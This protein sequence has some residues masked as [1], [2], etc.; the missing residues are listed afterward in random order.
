MG[1]ALSAF[2]LLATGQASPTSAAA[3]SERDPAAPVRMCAEWE[4]AFGTLIRW[5]L[6]IPSSLVIELASDDILYVLV[7]TAGEESSA[8]S[9]FS[10]WGIDLGQVE[11]IR[12]NTYSHWTRDWGPHCVFDGDG[13]YG[14]TDPIFDG[15]P[16]VGG[17]YMEGDRG[18]VPDSDRA[19]HARGWEED[20]AVNGVLATD[21]GCAL[22]ALP[23]Y[24]TG[25]NIMADGHGIA[26]STRRMVNENAPLMSEAAFRQEAEAYLGI[27]DYHF[28]DDPETNGIQHIDC[29][30]KILDEETIMVKEVYSGHPE[31]D[32]IERLVD[33]LSVLTNCYGR[34]Y[35]IVRV[36]CGTY[37]GNRVAAYTNSLILNKKVLVPLFDIS[38]D[39][40]ALQAYADAMPGYEVLGFHYGDWYYYDALHC[41]TMGIFDSHMLLIWHRR[42]E[43]EIPQQPYYDITAMIDDRS[44]AGLVPEDLLLYWQVSGAPTWSTELLT[45]AGIDS[46]AASIPWQPV[47]TTIAYYIAAADASGRSETLPRTAPLG[48]YE[49]TVGDNPGSVQDVRTGLRLDLAPTV[50]THAFDLR[51]HLDSPAPLAID[52][53]TLG[54][55]HIQRLFDGVLAA[56]GHRTR[57]DGRDEAGDFVPGG[58]Y[59]IRA[60]G[61]RGTVSKRCL[62]LR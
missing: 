19:G 38:T 44:E 33:Q 61:P 60:A 14:I 28:L 49:F 59:L 17:C 37:Q 40:A 26:F 6:G 1:F 4:P 43:A 20:D 45:P 42:L 35:N 21:L 32:C 62:R 11:F 53:F 57:W 2:L 24:C 18:D 9:T 10:S 27:S 25:G 52:V 36:Y 48:Y 47:G 15:Y 8:S 31:Y 46:F 54:G 13:L 34:P 3:G 12:A 7:E 39:D 51:L 29:Y 5:P 22:H 50:G 16:W 23:A 41:R 55:R 56:G 30:A 58:L